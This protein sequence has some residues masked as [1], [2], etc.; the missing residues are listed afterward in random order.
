[1][2][3]ALVKISNNNLF[4]DLTGVARVFGF[5]HTF[6]VQ[7]LIAIYNKDNAYVRHAIFKSLEDVAGK[8]RKLENK[9]GVVILQ[10]YILALNVI[11]KGSVIDIPRIVNKSKC[12]IKSSNVEQL[13]LASKGEDQAFI[14]I[15][16][17]MGLSSQ[18][19]ILIEFKDL[20]LDRDIHLPEVAARLGITPEHVKVLEN[21]VSLLTK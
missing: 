4:G 13:Y 11:S 12:S 20:L 18:S 14:W 16:K 9:E 8:T 1:L 10:N 15:L 6:I 2:I 7:I 5:K 19:K 3:I 21:F 17:N